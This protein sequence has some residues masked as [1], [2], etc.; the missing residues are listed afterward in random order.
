[1]G[2]GKTFK[3]TIEINGNLDPSVKAA[4]EKAAAAVDDMS[5]EVLATASA[6]AK[7]TLQMDK[8]EAAIKAAQEQYA[9][10][11]LEGKRGSKQAKELAKTI[12]AMDKELAQNKDALKAAE[13]A[14]EQLA[15]SLD[16]VA[17]A[18]EDSKDGFT[19]MKGAMADLV[20]DGISGLISWCADAAQSIYG[21]AEETREYREDINKLDT[22]F[23]SAGHTAE[24]ASDTYNAL[25]GVIGE[26]DQTVEASQQI[27]LL[28]DTEKD[29]ARWA[30]YAAG[31]VG[32][33]G[34]AL[35]PE[36]FYESANETF[37]LGE[38]TGAYTQMLEGAGYSVEEFNKYLEMCT[39]DAEKQ[40]YMLE[41]TDQI[42]GE[43]SDSYRKT[44][45]SIIAAREAQAEFTDIT[46]QMGEKLEPVTT[47]VQG[48]FNEILGA[49][50]E[51]MDQVDFT[52]IAEQVSNLREDCIELAEKGIAWLK[53]NADWL[54]PVLS[55]LTAGFVAF[56]TAVAISSVVTKLT[57]AMNGMTLAQYAV[58]TA[59]KAMNAAMNM[60][61]IMIIVGL[62]TTL[63]AAGVWLYRNWDTVK[64]KLEELGG[65]VSE[66]WGNISGWISGAIASIGEKFP[67]FGAYLE[68]WWS[69]I[70]A[71]VENVKSI[72][73]GVID[74]ISN[75]FAGNWSGAWNNVVQIFGDTFSMLVNLVKA[76]LNGVIS[77]VNRA[78]SSINKINVKI[79]DWAGGGELGFNIPSIP[80]LATG[81]FTDGVSIA[82]EAGTEA[83]I[84]FD[85]R[86][87]SQNIGY[88]TEAGR[89]LGMDVSTFEQSGT[90]NSSS[91]DFGGVTF[92]PNITITGNATK[93]DVLEAIREAEP[94]FMDMLEE[95]I[96]RRR[97]PV[98]A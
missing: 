16:D 95:L 66:I 8:Q 31:V 30:G 91:I 93:S 20:A 87:R 41:V 17:D 96:Q 21:L 4:I 98:Y 40:A 22:A 14:A 61:P 46:A 92:A 83:V 45:E 52:A 73:K 15:P 56:K 49:A 35:Q 74:F 37:K 68:G 1:M 36:T 76:P 11:V 58:T 97:E 62:I 53:D 75:V 19:V 25:Y 54:I 32:R 34:D 3:T 33:F 84:S 64:L 59:Q 26:T 38:A 94:E 42:L 5:D 29:A 79:P 80:M 10:Y 90:T 71:A 85:P 60:N 9:S 72:F 39:T 18:A 43:A 69:S 55:G 57:K 48:E 13:K 24:M 88:W 78:I 12:E 6:A 70:Q 50:L 28:A 89:M 44:N 86:Y 51:L 82:G 47:A 2:K 23:E 27:A 77:L 81:G 7:L 63:V 65:K 67:L